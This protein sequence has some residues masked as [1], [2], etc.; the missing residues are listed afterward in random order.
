MGEPW[1]TIVA[2]I[3]VY[4]LVRPAFRRPK[5]PALPD[6]RE[7]ERIEVMEWENLHCVLH[8]VERCLECQPLSLRAMSAPPPPDIW[9]EQIQ[10]I[11]AYEYKTDS[12]HLTTIKD[13]VATT[14]IV[15]RPVYERMSREAPP[16]PTKKVR[17]MYL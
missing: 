4:F 11:E 2:A 13:G 3:L 1:A 10:R 6:F 16:I 17:R 12:Y 8:G 9:D 5:Q 15:S 7:R 14:D